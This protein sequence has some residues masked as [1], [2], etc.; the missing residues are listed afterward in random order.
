MVS[1]KFYEALRWIIAIV[2]PAVGILITTLSNIWA[3]N[4]PAEEISLTLDA[5]GLFLGAVFG[6][7]KIV[8]DRKEK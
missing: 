8:Y 1:Q 7:S 2:L 3:W 5:I 6:I 4:I